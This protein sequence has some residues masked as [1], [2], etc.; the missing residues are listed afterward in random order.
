MRVVAALGGADVDAC[1]AAALAQL[2]PGTESL[3]NARHAEDEAPLDAGC[4]CPACKSYSRAYLHHVV[5]AGEIIAAM[6][7]T[8]HNLT[9]FQDLMRR[10]QSASAAS[11]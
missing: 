9:F 3:R 4:S 7:L 5:K 2:P 10:A 8:W 1:V 6:L 11:L